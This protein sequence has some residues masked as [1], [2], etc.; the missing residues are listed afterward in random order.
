MPRAKVIKITGKEDIFKLIVERVLGGITRV[1]AGR[2]GAIEVELT[3]LKVSIGN[4][5]FEF[6]GKTRLKVK[7]GR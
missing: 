4:V 6:T 7:I 5:T 2:A 1:L 3:G